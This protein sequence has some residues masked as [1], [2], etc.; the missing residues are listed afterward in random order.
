[1]VQCV[2]VDDNVQYWIK[3]SEGFANVMSK[4][5]E[6]RKVYFATLC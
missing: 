2:V 1:M 5:F 4:Y 3:I 6:F